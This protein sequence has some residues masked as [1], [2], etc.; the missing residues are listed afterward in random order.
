MGFLWTLFQAQTILNK[1]F[2]EELQKKPL[3]L[4]GTVASIPEKREHGIRFELEVKRTIPETLW[5]T[6]GKIRVV[7]KELPK[8]RN[9]DRLRFPAEQNIPKIGVGE[10]WQ[11]TVKL[12][13]PH[14]FANPGGFDLEKQL[15]QNSITA[16]GY[17]VNLETAKRVENALLS[18]PIDKFRVLIKNNILQVLHNSDFSGLIIALIVGIR[19]EIKKEDWNV[20]QK[21]GTS[22]L[23]AISGL[24]VGL[25]ASFVFLL[26][27]ILMRLLPAVCYINPVPQVA[28]LFALF[29]AF[30]YAF[31]AGFAV[32]T[33]RAL[34]M[35]TIFMGSILTR[36]QTHPWRSFFLSLG[37]VLLL[38]PLATLSSGFWL[39]FGAVFM[40]LYG[41]QG[42]IAPR[43]WWWRWGRAQ[44]VAFLGLTPITLWFFQ[45]VSFISPL[46]NLIA[47]PWVSFIVVPL[48]LIGASFSILSHTLSKPFL[49]LAEF[50]LQG[51]WCFLESCSQSSVAVWQNRITV[52]SF[53]ILGILSIS[54]FMILAPRGLPGRYLGVLGL[55]SLIVG[56]T[57]KLA[58]GIARVTVLDV[59]QGLAT[60]VETA[61]H[62]LVFDTG[63]KLS[64]NFNTGDRV[65]L[66]FLNVRGWQK[67]DTLIISHGDNDHVGGAKSILE[68]MP[69]TQ[70]ISSEPF[71]FPEKKGV[72]CWAGQSWTWEGVQFEMVHPDTINTR[73]RNDHSCVLKVTAGQ[74]SILLTADIEKKSEY[75]MIDRIGKKLKST[76]ML[77]PHHGSASSSAVEFIKAVDPKVAIIPFG[78]LNQYGHP[79][80]EVVA[81]YHNLGIQVLDTVR[82]GAITMLLGAETDM[83]Q[84]SQYRL[85]TGKYWTHLF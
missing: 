51:L 41:I 70:L 82:G 42:R 2:P 34:L 36:R 67:I 59:G 77:V 78:Y 25:V 17:L 53:L 23:M 68:K 83:P 79:K 81:R 48:S 84:V 12:K 1:Q 27:G 45:Q 62:V 14:G 73:K 57:V 40:I 58:P 18:H 52:E 80:A 61:K 74:Q 5:P 46:T 66:P 9:K 38:D 10:V 28:A 76:M 44:W 11:L 72:P 13:R 55:L 54:V 63:P 3:Q 15:F 21:T 31:L 26:T 60:V 56:K 24:H 47:I 16:E 75:K 29:S 37:F 71:L 32:P 30:L 85:E 7:C 69:V 4:L 35:L 6:P 49:K 65:V 19:D 64:E 39:S 22:H 50:S 20:F 33:K 43:G 8:Y